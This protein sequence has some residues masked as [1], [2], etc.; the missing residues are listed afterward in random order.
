MIGQGR[1]T[2]RRTAFTLI[3]L[4]AATTVTAV[5]GSLAAMLMIEASRVRGG[6]AVRVE[7]TETAARAMEQ[8][9]RYVRE[10][11]QDSGL[12]GQAQITT[13]GTSTL[14]FGAN[15]FRLTGADFEMSI[16][17]QATWAVM[18]RD[19]ASLTFR[20]YTADNTELT[21]APLTAAQCATVR[22]V[23]IELRLARG[24]EAVQMRTRVY[25]RNFQNEAA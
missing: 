6:A 20:Y 23:S 7:L 5:I 2:R 11:A 15:A 21:P 24:T 12:T 19:V 22:Q 17:A 3:E 1:H 4:L 16:D 14:A 13:A 9:L 8:A 25:L 18:A 10:I